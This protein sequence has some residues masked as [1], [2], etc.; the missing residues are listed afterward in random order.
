MTW[1]KIVQHFFHKTQLPVHYKDVIMWAIA[2]QITSLTIVFST[3]YSDVDQRK[4]QSSASLA[5]VQGIHRGPVNSPHKR[6]VTRK[7][8]PFEDVIMSR[9]SLYSNMTGRT[10]HVSWNRQRFCFAIFYS[11]CLAIIYYLYKEFM[12]SIYHFTPDR[13]P[14]IGTAQVPVKKTKNW[15]V[16]KPNEAWTVHF[17]L[18]TRSQGN[19]NHSSWLKSIIPTYIGLYPFI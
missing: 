9:F 12:W 4:H 15:R 18:L 1:F 13:I 17:F 7:M 19:V 8:F 3:V 10:Q 5:F 14:G 11:G 2:S 16:L 6:P